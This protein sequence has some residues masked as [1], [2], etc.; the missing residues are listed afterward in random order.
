LRVL[1][2]RVP[3]PVALDTG[4]D[5]RLRAPVE[6]AAGRVA[7]RDGGA[8]FSGFPADRVPAAA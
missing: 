6:I 4:R 7:S 2:A 1:A 8:A 5:E 3:V